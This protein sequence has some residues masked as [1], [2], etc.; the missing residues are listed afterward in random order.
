MINLSV[1]LREIPYGQPTELGRDDDLLYLEISVR[2][3]LVD[4]RRLFGERGIIGSASTYMSLVLRQ[5]EAATGWNEARRSLH[6]VHRLAHDEVSMMPL[7]QIV[8]HY[9][10]NTSLTGVAKQSASLYQRVEQWQA[11]APQPMEEP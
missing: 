7:W 1:E 9:A 5:L 4:A 10:Y 11:K 6:D 8:D 3:P 2:E